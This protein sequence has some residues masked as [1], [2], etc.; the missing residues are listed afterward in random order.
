LFINIL[1][2]IYVEKILVFKLK[3]TAVKTVSPN[4]KTAFER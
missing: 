4:L 2:L 3:K 1:L